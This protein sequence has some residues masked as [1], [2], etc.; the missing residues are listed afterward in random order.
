[1]TAFPKTNHYRDPRLLALAEGREC[2]LLVPQVC[3]QGE[4][5]ACHSNNGFAGKGTRIK[6][7][8]FFTVWGCPRC[9]RWLDESYSASGEER[10]AAFD[11]AYTRQ[12]AAW[13]SLSI[14][15]TEAERDRRAARDAL[16][17]Y[18]KWSEN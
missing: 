5:V 16:M 18:E 12:L 6:A 7:H 13:L 9:H 17:A 11:A 1:M 14:D 8:D 4:T 2:L 10:Q 3:N 15:Q